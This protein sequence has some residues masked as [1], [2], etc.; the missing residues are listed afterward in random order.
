MEERKDRRAINWRR[1]WPHNEVTHPVAG[2]GTREGPDIQATVM[3]PL[4]AENQ[5]LAKTQR[6]YR[7]WLDHRNNIPQILR[8]VF[9]V[10]YR[11]VVVRRQELKKLAEAERNISKLRAGS[12][13]AMYS[14]EID[15][16]KK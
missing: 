14:D 8:E 16:G 11:N 9:G 12:H 15:K 1:N 5:H 3:S 10:L 7:M 6:E 4:T 13:R 2:V